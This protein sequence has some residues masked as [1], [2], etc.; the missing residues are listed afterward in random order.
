MIKAPISHNGAVAILRLSD[1]VEPVELYSND[2][3]ALSIT[4]PCIKNP[5]FEG[6]GRVPA[7]LLLSM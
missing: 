7:E 2:D 1:S 3:D 6:A 5:G 4:E